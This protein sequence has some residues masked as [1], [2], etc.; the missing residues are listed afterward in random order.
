MDMGWVE[1]R[2]SWEKEEMASA[3]LVESDLAVLFDVVESKRC[4]RNDDVRDEDLA[5]MKVKR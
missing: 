2:R 5:E 3:V 1:E 4:L